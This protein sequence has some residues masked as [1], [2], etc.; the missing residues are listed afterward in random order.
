MQRDMV[1]AAVEE[2]PQRNK[3]GCLENYPLTGSQWSALS[4]GLT[5]SCLLL[6]KE[7]FSAGF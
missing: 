5:C 4:C 1:T 6:Q 7:T 2:D 3:G